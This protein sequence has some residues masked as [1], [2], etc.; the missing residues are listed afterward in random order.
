MNTIE[1][2]PIKTRI[3]ES[4]Q[5]A[6]DY[7]ACF[8]YNDFFSPAVL[9]QPAL[10]DSLTDFYQSLPRDRSNDTLHGAF[11]DVTVHS[12]DTLI[13][14]ASEKRIC[15]SMEIAAKLNIRGV[16]FHTN[17]LA[18][19]QNRE[20]LD[21]WLIC[22]REFFKRLSDQYPNLQIYMENMFDLY[23]LTYAAFGKAMQ[24]CPNISLCFDIAHAHL[25]MTP[26]SEWIDISYPYIGHIHLNDNDGIHDL[27]DSIGL[28]TVNWDI[29]NT[30]MKKYKVQASVLVEIGSIE[31]QQISLAYLKEHHIFPFE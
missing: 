6:D 5:L 18:T 20:Y 10:L 3:E 11:L 9:D 29:Y 14:Q 22:N 21:N 23:P 25:S 8:E 27:H 30:W 17:L 24:D 12:S 31:K 4:L 2:I 13:R 16:V 7:N 19:F 28:G 15:Q 1:I 26:V